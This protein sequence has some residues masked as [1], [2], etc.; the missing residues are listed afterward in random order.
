MK[1]RQAALAGQQLLHRALLDVAL[2]GDQRLQ[3]ADQRIRIPQR[4]G[5]GVLFGETVEEEE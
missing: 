1:T 4:L 5:D 3:R 2:L